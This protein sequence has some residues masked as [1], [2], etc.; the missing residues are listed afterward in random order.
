MG[1]REMLLRSLKIH[2]ES[3]FITE[4]SYQLIPLSFSFYVILIHSINIINNNTKFKVNTH[5]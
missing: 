2:F 5:V 3:Q 1:E 4:A